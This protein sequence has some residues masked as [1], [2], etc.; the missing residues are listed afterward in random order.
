[1]KAFK[2]LSNLDITANVVIV[3]DSLV[4]NV[5]RLPNAFVLLSNVTKLGNFIKKVSKLW[6]SIE[7]LQ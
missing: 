7:I 6:L 5:T 3:E 4:P 2:E 1:M